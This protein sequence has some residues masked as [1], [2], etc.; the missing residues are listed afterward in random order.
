MIF[1]HTQGDPAFGSALIPE[2]DK[3]D[4]NHPK[5]N[6]EEV[7]R[8][9]PEGFQAT[10]EHQNPCFHCLRRW[11]YW[12]FAVAW[13]PPGAPQVTSSLLFLGWPPSFISLPGIKSL[14]D[15]WSPGTPQ[16]ALSA[17]TY[18]CPGEDRSNTYLLTDNSFQFF[19]STQASLL[20]SSTFFSERLDPGKWYI[21]DRNH[22]KNN[23][24]EVSRSTHVDKKN[25]K[26]LLV[27][28]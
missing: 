17:T 2:S 8:G 28:W 7:S 22:P 25:W 9:A 20:T 10:I 26:E 24:V 23:D 4:G 3:E 19:L 6:G 18:Y 16:W 14:S 15:A 27:K 5:K 13:N 11:R 21:G 1:E 12:C